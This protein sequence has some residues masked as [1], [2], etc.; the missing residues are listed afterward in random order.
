M[1]TKIKKNLKLALCMTMLLGLCLTAGIAPAQ[2]A[3]I[4]VKVDGNP[5]IFPDQAPYLDA[6]DRT[7]VPIRFP[8]EALGV[9]VDLE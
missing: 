6:Q 5:V 3:A 7:L 2:G 9:T 4:T 1:K 8:M